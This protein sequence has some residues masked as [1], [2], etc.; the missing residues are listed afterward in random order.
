MPNDC[1]VNSFGGES[2]AETM[3]YL[4]VGLEKIV[5]DEPGGIA[6][7]K[8]RSEVLKSS[9]VLDADGKMSIAHS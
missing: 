6:S 9:V 5:T 7:R 3:K 8:E 4:E 1:V 2:N